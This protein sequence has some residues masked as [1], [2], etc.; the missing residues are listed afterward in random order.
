MF[1]KAK[2][3]EADLALMEVDALP[4][5]ETAP[6]KKAN[7]KNAPRPK[8]RSTM[9]GVPSIISGDV[10]IRGAIE[11]EGEVQFDGE[12]EGD[13][14]AK[15]L[16]IGDG[17]RVAGEVVAERVRVSGTVEGAIRAT[18]VELA[19]GA[20]VKGDIMHTALAIEAGAKFE[21]NVRHSDDPIGQGALPAASR[22]TAAP[23]PAGPA[24]TPLQDMAAEPAAD[25]AGQDVPM[26]V[27]EPV[28]A[29]SEPMT[30]KKH[31]AN[32]R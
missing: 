31:K 26:P 6:V 10:V 2:N 3:K 7:G 11:S 1:S 14:R 19:E 8:P 23:A 30:R 21:G 25:L 15:G 9:P 13:I 12:I 17:A 28:G 20:L 22:A 32:L 29:A 5:P 18:R 16:I 24:P 4:S 27:L